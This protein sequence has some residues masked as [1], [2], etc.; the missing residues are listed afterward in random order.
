MATKRPLKK[1][2]SSREIKKDLRS[3]Y[4]GK[5]GKMPNLKKLSHKRQSPLTGM[6]IKL[7][8]F[9]MIVSA[10]AWT[11]FFL[12]TQGLFQDN[13]TLMIEIEGPDE[14]R[15]G[16][17][18][19]YTIRY[20]NGGSVPIA[21]LTMK[22]NLPST[23]HTFTTIPEASADQEW[24]V[25]SL[26][27]GSDGAVTLTGVFLAEVESAQRLQALFTYKPANFSS[28]FQDIA[29]YK[30]DVTESVVALT[31]SGPE[32]ALAGDEAEYIINIQNT[33]L[34]PVYN[35]RVTPSL[36][37][38]FTITETDPAI[39]DGLTY[40]SIDS[41]DAGELEALTLRGSFTSSASGDQ[42]IGVA[43]GF[44]D[45]DLF[46]QQASEELVT[47]V[48]G[49]ALGFSLIIN[50]S[51]TNQTAELGET[52]RLSIDYQNNS[53]E[54]VSD[55]GFELNLSSSEGIIPINW[56]DADI[57]GGSRSGNTITFSGA[58]HD[59][60]STLQ[61]GADDVIDLSLP[62]DSSLSG[63]DADTFTISLKAILSQVGG[64][65]G[66]R[67]IDTTPITV[68]INSDARVSAHARY[69]SEGGT[70]I[71][72]GPLPPEVGETTSYRVYWNLS[73][74]LHALDDVEFTTTLPQDVNWLESTD[75]DIGSVSYNSTTRQVSWT[76][77][78]MPTSVEN[79]G[80]WFGVAINPAEGDVGRFIKL[81]NPT[82]FTA[83]DAATDEGL[84]ETLEIVS[85][86]LSSDAFGEGKG[87]VIN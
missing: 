25:G 1:R 47:D 76:I 67:E 24:T 58:T 9:L 62:I 31:L 51:N 36:P 27:P 19:S 32:K 60:L 56:T 18:V 17:E 7:I 30:V 79:A 83:T 10:L 80:A 50:G 48:L 63:A 20:E 54:D 86:D 61:A 15:S 6:L 74:G 87:V 21:S 44:V 68:Q 65:A 4:T 37:D 34:D 59:S 45:E 84:S 33:N 75:T 39:T 64:V 11:G 49:G 38:D 5:D 52:L 16:E 73:N 57:D 40:W 23:F 42:N 70:A 3:I 41:L 14:V 29:T 2:R 55:M 43:A 85:S 28:E 71:G 53:K 35:L 66:T 22:L 72:S 81:T 26:T 77:S 46:L 69:Y 8:V 12:F 82:S 78:R 13:E